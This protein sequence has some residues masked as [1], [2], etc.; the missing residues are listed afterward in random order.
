MQL[1]V[2]KLAVLGT[3]VAAAAFGGISAAPAPEIDPGSVAV[4]FV[5]LGGAVLMIRS[6]IR[7]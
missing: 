5:L 2:L 3:L 1:N 4:P 7:R 6:R